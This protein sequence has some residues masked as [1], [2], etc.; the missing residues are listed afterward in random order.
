MN[1][2]PIVIARLEADRTLWDFKQAIAELVRDVELKYWELVLAQTQ[3][4]GIEKDIFLV[5]A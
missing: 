4:Q 1:R 5:R 2:A 3:L